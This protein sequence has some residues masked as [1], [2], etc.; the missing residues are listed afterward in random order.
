MAEPTDEEI[1]ED[2][3]E[4]EEEEEAEEEEIE[5]EAPVRQSASYFVG[6]RQ[7]RKQAKKE[8]EDKDEEPEL[9]EPA[10]E[11]IRKQISPVMNAMKKQADDIELRE[12]FASNPNDRK[13]EKAIRNRMEKWPEVPVGDIA[14]VVKFGK[15][16]VQSAKKKD[17]AVTEVRGRALRGSSARAEEVKLPQTQEEF[18]AIYK[19]VKKGESVKLG[20]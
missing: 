14:K 4:V 1:I 13:Y 3:E 12:H 20:E 9:T 15:E 6:L 7:G 16:E 8:A 10:A 17:A 11:A 5:D 2:E 19:R 18:A